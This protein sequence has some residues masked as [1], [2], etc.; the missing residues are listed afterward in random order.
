MSW[1]GL[2]PHWYRTRFS[3]SMRCECSIGSFSHSVFVVTLRVIPI[4]RNTMNTATGPEI[5]HFMLNT[6]CNAWDLDASDESPGVCRF[7]YRDRNRISSQPAQVQRVLD[8][9]AALPDVK[10]IVFTG[11]DPLMPYDNHIT[12]AMRHAKELGFET[13]LHTNGIL[14]REKYASIAQWLDVVTLALDGPDAFTADWFRGVG[15]FDRFWKNIE[16]LEQGPHTLGI[17][18]FTSSASITKIPEL[19]EAVNGLH[20][21]TGVEYWLLSQYRPIGR[22]DERKSTIYGYDRELFDDAANRARE[23]LHDD[24]SLFAQPTRRKDEPYPLRLWLFSDGRLSMDSGSVLST[25]NL[26]IGNVLTSSFQH[27]YK[28]AV[29]QHARYN[30]GTHT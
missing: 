26:I 18:T 25:T 13:N 5:V 15:Y 14:L 17:N 12:V 4:E 1:N 7:C 28:K 16:L 3:R 27:L 11:G 23:V 10:R 22:A 29:D 30:G 24:V 2:N 21:R 20:D 6:D 19:A 8:S 9:V